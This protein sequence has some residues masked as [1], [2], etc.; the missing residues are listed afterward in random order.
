[1][2]C[3]H[4][5]INNFRKMYTININKMVKNNKIIFY[6][7]LLF[8]PLDKIM[9]ILKL[10]KWKDLPENHTGIT[11]FSNGTLQYYLNGLLHREDGPAIIRKD[12]R[13]EYWLNDENITEEV[14]EWIKE[15]KI[16]KDWNNS[17]KI[18]F[19]LTFG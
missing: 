8:K 19:K 9:Y 6:N 13:K 4:N 14:E 15:N 11:E 5:Y 16:P 10:D 1:M 18:L 7:T 17:H 3:D 12:G 2:F